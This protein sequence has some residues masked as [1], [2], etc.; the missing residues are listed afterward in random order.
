MSSK[1]VSYIEVPVDQQDGTG[2]V[3]ARDL[4]PWADPYIARIVLKH[5]LQVAR[6]ERKRRAESPSDPG[7]SRSAGR[8]RGG[9]TRFDS[10][11]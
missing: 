5:E 2:P 10:F 4:L 7:W 6:E 1:T 3:A 8:H 11:G 9:K